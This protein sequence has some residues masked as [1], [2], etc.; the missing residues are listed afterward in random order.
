MPVSMS[1]FIDAGIRA[2]IGINNTY[3]IYIEIGGSVYYDVF[4]MNW[5]ER[6]DLWNAYQ[7][8]S[9][10]RNMG[11]AKEIPRMKTA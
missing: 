11:D 4:A 10:S 8:A 5:K 7:R 1:D 9:D 2:E 6:E 3:R